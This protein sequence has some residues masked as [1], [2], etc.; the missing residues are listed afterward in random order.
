MKNEGMPVVQEGIPF[1]LVFL[2]AA[3]AFAVGGLWQAVL[4]CLLVLGYVA[5]FFRNPERL[6]PVG[7]SMVA[8]PADG[9]VI[10]VGSATEPEFSKEVR[11][12]VSIFMSLWDVH[13]NRFPVD[14]TVKDM[15][16]R[17]GSFLA[18]W[19][20]AASLENER[21]ALLVET[22]HGE[23]LVVVQVAGLIAR[24]IICYP[25]IGSFVLKGQ[26]FGLIRF[27]SRVDVYL[28]L[29]AEV[30]VKVGERTLGGETILAKLKES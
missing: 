17:R 19:E 24:R 26:R 25:S 14:G 30:L 27:G 11:Q 16:Y 29:D 20:E 4:P 10:Y 15:K 6:A 3:V 13:V 22:N 9:K 1:L 28:P 18:A 8:C 21:N 12:K 7:A 23:R 5:F 2:L